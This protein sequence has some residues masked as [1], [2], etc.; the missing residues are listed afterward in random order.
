[1]TVNAS[2]GFTEITIKIDIFKK[3]MINQIALI[4]AGCAGKD[5]V[6]LSELIYGVW[7]LADDADTSIAH[8]RKKID[9][10]LSIGMTTF[11]HADIYGDY[12]CEAL[13]GKALKEAPELREQMQLISKCGIGLLSDKFPNRRVKLYD[14]SKHYI[15]QSVDNSLKYLHTDYLDV[16]LIHRPDPFMQVED[17][18]AALDELVDSGKVLAVG[19]SNFMPW[20]WRLLQKYM[21]HRLLIN[22]IELSVLHH[23]PLTDGTMASIQEDALLPM[24]WSSL[25]G[26]RLFSNDADALRVKPVLEKIATAYGCG[27]D[28]VA[29]AWLLAHPANILPVIGT[30]R[31]DRIHAVAKAVEISLD[32]ETWFEIYTAA[33]GQEVP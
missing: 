24:A 20:D 7:R 8:V 4:G 17:T 6:Q 3:Y 25:A 29:L 2:L 30:N 5:S 11:D 18:A 19:V 33:M 32:R 27:I 26:G 13:F 22:Q 31:I 15:H 9:A 28:A 10:C 12:S 1:M 21:R 14:T 23:T 16:L